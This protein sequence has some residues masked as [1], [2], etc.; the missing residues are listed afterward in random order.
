MERH[1]AIAADILAPL[2]FLKD[3]VPLI[4]FHHERYAGGGYPSG[5]TGR[6]IPLGARIISVADSFNAMVSDRPYRSGLPFDTAVQ[7][8]RVN[9]GSQFDPDVVAAFLEVLEDR[10]ELPVPEL[11][12]VPSG[13]SEERDGGALAANAGE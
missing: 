4:L 9:S 11:R 6:A 13:G 8:L 7:E 2:D 3:A 10:G 1:P 12:V 5:V